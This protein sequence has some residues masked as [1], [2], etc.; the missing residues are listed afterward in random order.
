MPAATPTTTTTWSINTL[1]RELA[2]GYVFTAH[3]SVNAV[4]STLNPEGN[5][6]SQGAYGSVGLERPEGDLI[7]FDELTQEQV[8]GW[9]KAKLGG[10]EK[11]A[12]IEKALTD[13]LAEVISPSRING[14]PW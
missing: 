8:I 6:Y 9:V 12:E 7:A 14:V 2:D 3:Y 5:P 10:D 1:E 13:R 4:S 11:V